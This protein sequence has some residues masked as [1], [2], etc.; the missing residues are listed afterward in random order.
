MK[1]LHSDRPGPLTTTDERHFDGVQPEPLDQ[2]TGQRINS[3][4]P[5]PR[6]DGNTVDLDKEMAKLAENQL[7]FQASQRA[8]TWKFRLLKNAIVES[9]G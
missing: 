6:L 2:V 4:N 1:A 7:M 5:D 9:K 8:I 3:H